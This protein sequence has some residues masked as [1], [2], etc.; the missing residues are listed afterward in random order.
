MA[1][2]ASVPFT[3]L[4]GTT[5]RRASVNTLWCLLGCAIGDL[6]TILFFQL[7][8]IPWPT[9]WIMAL[10]MFNGILTSIILETLILLRQ[11]RPW[12]AL[13]TAAGMSLISMIGMELAMNTVDYL[14]VGGARLTWLRAALDAAGGLPHAAAL[15]L[16]APAGPGKELPLTAVFC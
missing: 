5:W 9:L 4:S 7:T 2:P 6:G 13:R 12:D 15:Q 8:G 14:I 1:A 3:W 11:M 10:A 16:L